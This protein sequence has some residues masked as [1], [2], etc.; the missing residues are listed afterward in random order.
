MIKVGVIAEYNPFHNG[1]LYHLK[2][3]KEMFK[4][5]TL[6]LVLIGNFTQRGDVS[7]I[8]KWDKTRLALNYGFDLV[9]ELP[10]LYATSMA[11]IYA[12]DA[13]EILNTLN[14]DYL[15]FGSETNDVELLKKLALITKDNDEYQ[16]KVRTFLKEGNNYP[17]ACSLAL[18]D[19]SGVM[20]D[21][22][23]DVL[24]LEYVRSIINT[25][26]KIKPVSIK[27]TNDY[28]ETNVTGNVASATSIRKNMDNKGI[29]SKVMPKD[30][31]ELCKN[32]SL[33]DYFKYLK[34]QVI[35]SDS[36]NNIMDVNEGIDNKIRKEI[37]KVNTTN[38]LILKL[39]SK[40]YAYN[41]IKRMLLHVLCN[42][43]KE[44]DLSL[45][46]IRI[47]GL[48][49]KGKTVLKEAQKEACVPII[50]KVKKEHVTLLKEDIKAAKVYSLIADYDYKS[51]FNASIKKD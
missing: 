19:V 17:K 23:N 25:N 15:V 22:P 42:T 40:R 26:S 4:D 9:A 35:T 12:R 44:A 36:L 3:V 50:T 10:F 28:H 5:A 21:K 31:L 38:E 14:C 33:N 13:I 6:I 49:D 2:K 34:Y 47:L 41:R 16:D 24:A 46:Y 18:N 20:I 43:K 7:V 32:I 1:H 30:A 8:N 45:K 39:K 48:N 11:S 29:I 37:L 27:R 51:E